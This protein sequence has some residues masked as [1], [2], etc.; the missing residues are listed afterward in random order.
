MAGV[1]VAAIAGCTT[2]GN[3]G[4]EFKDQGYLFDPPPPIT[5]KIDL[6]IPFDKVEL[7][8]DN[9]AEL[10]EFLKDLRTPSKDRNVLTFG[11]IVVTGHTEGIGSL[12]ENMKVSDRLA[13]MAKEYLVNAENVSPTLIFW[14]GM[15]SKQPVPVTKFC[16]NKMRL[17]QR[18]ECLAP[19]RRVTIEVVGAALPHSTVNPPAYLAA[20]P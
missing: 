9:K 1:A 16:D 4:G 18:I 7:T 8:A 11:A 15:G 2:T 5:E 20:Q 13:K 14:E 3:V 17:K 12:S 10:S 19:N 6:H